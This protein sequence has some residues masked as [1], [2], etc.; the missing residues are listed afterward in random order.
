M[1]DCSFAVEIDPLTASLIER[2]VG[3]R[4]DGRMASKQIFFCIKQLFEQDLNALRLLHGPIQLGRCLL[5]QRGEPW[6]IIGIA[7]STG[8]MRSHQCFLES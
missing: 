5:G 2:V 6:N 1:S 7:E 3:K 4:V 8:L